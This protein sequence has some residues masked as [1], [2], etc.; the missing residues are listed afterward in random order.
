MRRRDDRKKMLK[1]VD[2]WRG[3]LK[4]GGHPLCW[5]VPD[6][7]DPGS[8]ELQQMLQEKIQHVV[9]YWLAP[10]CN[11]D[12]EVVRCTGQ[13]DEDQVVFTAV[14]R[15]VNPRPVTRWLSQPLA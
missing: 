8:A 15:D 3:S 6:W 2:P 7:L 4:P 12:M 13:S 1:R 9:T 10:G 5:Y 14:R 11:L